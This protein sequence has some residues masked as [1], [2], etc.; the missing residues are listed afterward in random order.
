M[1]GEIVGFGEALL[2]LQGQ[3]SLPLQD[4]TAFE[5]FVGGTELNVLAAAHIFGAKVLWVSALPDNPLGRKIYRKALAAGVGTYIIWH[6]GRVGLYFYEK[7]GEGGRVYYDRQGSAFAEAYPEE[8]N[9]DEILKDAELFHTSGVTL[10]LSPNARKGAFN[11]KDVAKK[12][13]LEVSFDTNYRQTLWTV[14]EAEKVMRE[15]AEGVDYLF[16]S[17]IEAEGLFGLEGSDEEL[18]GGLAEL[19]GVKCV[20]LRVGEEGR[21][22]HTLVFVEGE[23]LEENVGPYRIVDRIGAGDAFVGAFLAKRQ[24]G[25]E[26]ALRYGIN[27]YKAKCLVRGDMLIEDVPMDNDSIRR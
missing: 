21:F 13:G 17:N 6:E 5:V 4:A 9:W 10:A 26:V 8:Y 1:K 11:A 27:A 20:V 25:Y 3:L 12:R 19:L 2:R 24:A 22:V 23:I 7:F 18:A 16:T 14:E 15:Y